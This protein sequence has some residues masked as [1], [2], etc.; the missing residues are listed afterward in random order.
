MKIL[1]IQVNVF[2][3]KYLYI[4]YNFSFFIKKVIYFNIKKFSSY[5]NTL[6]QLYIHSF[7][8]TLFDV[9]SFI[10]FTIFPEHWTTEIIFVDVINTSRLMSIQHIK[11]ILC[12]CSVIYYL[13][14]GNTKV[15]I[16]NI[17]QVTEM[18]KKI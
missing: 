4:D 14:I 1:D 17:F 12:S 7:I 3:K 10:L 2:V 9:F 13:Y 16:I 18:F 15:R 11:N 8:K 6:L 5:L